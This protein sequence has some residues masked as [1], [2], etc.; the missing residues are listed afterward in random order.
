MKQSAKRFLAKIV[1]WKKDKTENEFDQERIFSLVCCS[2]LTIGF[3]SSF[4][5]AKV[6]FRSKAAGFL[7]QR[8]SS[9]ILWRARNKTK[10]NRVPTRKCIW[11]CFGYVIEFL[12]LIRKMAFIFHISK[13]AEQGVTLMKLSKTINSM[14]VHFCF[15]KWFCTAVFTGLIQFRPHELGPTIQA[16][17]NLLS[18][19]M[20]E[21]V[22][23]AS[24]CNP[25]IEGSN[26]TKGHYSFFCCDFLVCFYPPLFWLFHSL[27]KLKPHF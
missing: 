27:A 19:I 15:N 12:M 16:A 4:S 22:A 7:C 13:Q 1:K 6:D 25:G 9:V 3:S 18:W 14:D 11:L 24:S 10:K 17:R 21:S 2:V 26:H 20:C 8:G 5:G 23:T